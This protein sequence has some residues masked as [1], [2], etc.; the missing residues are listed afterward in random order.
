L[1]YIIRVFQNLDEGDNH[2]GRPNLEKAVRLVSLKEGV[3]YMHCLNE[4]QGKREV[5]EI[6]KM[7]HGFARLEKNGKDCNVSF[8]NT[9]ADLSKVILRKLG[10]DKNNEEIIK[11]IEEDAAKRNR[12]DKESPEPAM[13]PNG[14]IPKM[15]ASSQHSR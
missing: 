7:K 5:A 9:D 1:I 3:V 4:E 11:L 13:A 14:M 12:S 15:P 8:P 2:V 10:A 6:N